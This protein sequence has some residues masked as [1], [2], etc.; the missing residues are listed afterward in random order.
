MPLSRLLISPR[1]STMLLRLIVIALAV[2]AFP[3]VSAAERVALVIGNAAYREDPLDNPVNDAKAMA[4]RLEGF[5]FAVTTVVDADLRTMQRA[6][7]AFGEQIEARS[8]ALVFY[9][10]HGVQANGRNY[11]M[12]VDAEAT[13]ER[14]LRFEA[15]DMNDILEEI[16]LAHPRMSIVIMDACRNN[17]FEKK[18]R[19]GSRGLAVVDAATGTLIAYSTAPGSVAADGDGRNGLYTE[20]LLN[21]LDTPGLKVEEVFKQVRRNVSELSGGRQIPWE[22]SSL[23]GDF[24]FNDSGPAPGESGASPAV[25]AAGGDKESLF[26]NTIK[27]SDRKADFEDYVAQYPE[28]VFRGIANR[29][30]AELTE[31]PPASCDD[32]TGSWTVSKPELEGS[33]ND[34]LIASKADDGGYK[35]DYTVCGALDAITNIKGT[36]TFADGTLSYKWSSF[37][38][39][40]TTD[41]DLEASCQTGQGRVV[42]RKGLPGVCNVFV[43]KNMKLAITRD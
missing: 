23:T 31:N 26:W 19:G 39:G 17:P 37:P 33:C 9:A 41:F 35:V 43:N 42:K 38:C 5:G 3:V 11:L 36:A 21:A 4:E 27:A 32:L 16:E 2:F 28:G 10:G 8:T 25:A 20:Q 34:R 15:V 29:R 30:I 13:A 1:I 18:L 22:S 6:I 7:L 14:E 24:V 40:G 12:P